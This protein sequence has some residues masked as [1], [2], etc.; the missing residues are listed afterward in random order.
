[1]AYSDYG[2]FVY[3][4]EERRTDKE[5]VGVYDTDEANLPSGI[6]VFANILK[7]KD[8]EVEWW[9]RSQHGVMGDGPVRVACYKQGFPS[10]YVWRDGDEKPT[11]IP[12]EEIIS[13]NGWDDGYVSEYN[14]KKYVGFDY[15]FEDF[16]VPGLEG[17]T[18]SA[19][20]SSGDEAPAYSARMV[21]PDGSVW[22]CNYDYGYG[23]G[24]T[25]VEW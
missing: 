19:H 18:F 9:E 20:G 12:E 22:E 1:M 25:D 13:H 11:L 6:R 17:Y 10:F 21:E 3:K 16:T 23:A 5:D 7:N 15:W 4:N 24:I 14:G 8:R 2:A